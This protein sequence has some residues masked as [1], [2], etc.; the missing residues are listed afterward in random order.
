MHPL[1]FRYCISQE[2]NRLSSGTAWSCMSSRN[3]FC[4]DSGAFRLFRQ[5]SLEPL[6]LVEGNLFAL[7]RLDGAV[8]SR[9]EEERTRQCVLLEV[10]CIFRRIRDPIS[11]LIVRTSNHLRRSMPDQNAEEHFRHRMPRT[12]HYPSLEQPIV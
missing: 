5:C 1:A 4:S 12:V 6:V 3:F 2:L 10:F 11:S 8:E 9:I 7:G